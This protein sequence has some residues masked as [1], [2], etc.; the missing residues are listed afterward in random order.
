MGQSLTIRIL[1]SRSM[2]VALISPTLSLRRTSCGILPSRICLRISGTHL[3]QSE[4][5]VRGQP[6]GGFS[7][8]YDLSSGL[9]LH[10]GVKLGLGLMRLS[11]SNTAHAP[12]AA[13][14]TAF[15]AYFV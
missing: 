15:S 9:S 6:S 3:G 14:T 13:I 1:P 7:F 10:L 12:L 4:S 5:V 2:M 11:R 8:W